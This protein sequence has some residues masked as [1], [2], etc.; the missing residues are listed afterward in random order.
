MPNQEVIQKYG[1]T[2]SAQSHQESE[3]C[4]SNYI[5]RNI[6]NFSKEF[7]PANWVLSLLS[8]P[9]FNCAP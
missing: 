6:L 4:I 3:H 7:N 8:S 9:L 5:F 1:A 2:G